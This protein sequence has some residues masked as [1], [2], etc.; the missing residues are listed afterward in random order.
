M[1]DDVVVKF[2]VDDSGLLASF[3]DIAEQTEELDDAMGDLSENIDDA[4][5]P[6]SVQNLGKEVKKTTKEVDKI[7]KSVKKTSV[8]M[9]Q[10]NRTGGRG[11]SMLS[12]FGGVGGK[13][14]RAL[15]GLSFALAS[16][17]F[18]AFALASAAAAAAYSFFADK[19][20]LNNDEIIEKNEELR[21][22]IAELESDVSSRFREGKLLSVDLED[23]TDAE[24]ELKKIFLLEDARGKQNNKTQAAQDVFLKAET[25]IKQGLFD[26]TTEKL[27]L[28]K[29][30][31]EFQ[32]IAQ[33][34]A[35]E[36]LNIT[37]KITQLKQAGEER[38]KKAISDRIKAEADASKLFEGLIRNEL[39]IRLTALDN[40]AKAR[41][42]RFNT[43]GQGASKEKA[44]LA[45]SQKVLLQ[46]RADVTAEFA[47]AELKARQGLLAQFIID[48][49]KA[50]IET[51]KIDKDNRALQIEVIAKDGEEK[52]ALTIQNEEKLQADL[53]AITKKFADKRRDE[54]IKEETEI[55]NIKSA[56]FEADIMRQIAELET[57]LE[58][59]RQAKTGILTSE[60]EITAFKESQAD[61][62]LSAELSFQIAR[63][64]LVRDFN[65][66]I[67]DE[68]KA[69]L[70]AQISSLEAQLQGV[71]TRFKKSVKE[72]DKQSLGDLMGLSDDTQSD[73]SAVQG[74]LEQVTAE[75][76][77]AV[78][79]R[80]EI[81]QK[82]IDFRTQR[83]SEIQSDLANEIEL[84]KLGKASNIKQLQEQLAAEKAARAKAEED[85]KAAAQ[86]QFAIDTALQASNLITA[87]SALYS[88]LSGLPF[89]IGVALAT[90]L[91]GVMIGAFVASKASAASAA[92]FAEGGQYG[93]TGDGAKYETSNKLGNKPYDYHRGE[94]ILDAETTRELGLD[95]LPMN[96]ARNKLLGEHKS[97]M[98]SSSAASQKNKRINNQINAN[99][100]LSKSERMQALS[101]GFKSAIEGQSSILKGI[102]TATE[103][104]PI[105][106]DM[107]NGKYLIERGKN[108]KE[109]KKIN[110]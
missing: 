4:F 13:A 47:A 11:I 2:I 17:P 28:E 62:R 12:R 49:E 94:Y 64:K 31:L 23:I 56:A 92:G 100:K 98:P 54:N 29:Q 72:K 106:F 25:K 15:G 46:D 42:K 40:E 65:K 10:M 82:E 18:G 73:I 68:E 41:E 5:K 48:E 16:S 84:N 60:E 78:A 108:K 30:V 70:N 7:D 89:G 87:I 86:A 14:T 44:F 9:A 91:S 59:D 99:S 74:A 24:K 81:L 110:K 77:K 33:K 8:S 58:L 32:L 104:A 22:S 80:I 53:D 103:N 37:N 71:G 61:E 6:R 45:E 95:G 107:G 69:S 52:A 3:A 93:Y 20:G 39:Q 55:F 63:L 27:E 83:I 102:L 21:K 43:L 57:K 75:I 66:Q 19:L 90:V 79:A 51:A 38:T 88:S 67:T 36:E 85:Q 35:V 109:I 101:D 26:S 1:A 34:S 96:E 105:V 97:D 76:S 50:A